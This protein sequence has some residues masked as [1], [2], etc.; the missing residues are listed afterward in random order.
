MITLSNAHTG[1]T[2][3]PVERFL[4]ARHR[5]NNSGC[6]L[7]HDA[8]L[9]LTGRKWRPREDRYLVRGRPGS[10]QYNP[11]E[12]GVRVG[13]QPR[14][15]STRQPAL[16]AHLAGTEPTAP[17]GLCQRLL[18]ELHAVSVD[19]SPTS[20]QGEAAPGLANA[21][22][23]PQTS[24]AHLCLDLPGRD[25]N[26]PPCESPLLRRPAV[27][28]PATLITLQMT[29]FLVTSQRKMTRGLAWEMLTRRNTGGRQ[30]LTR[31]PEA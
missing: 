11:R 14:G 9:H 18:L 31:R 12:P 26:H 3:H 19:E 22:V 5:F 16:S 23:K 20:L 17:R 30:P 1:I 25:L 21:G 7:F 13:S 28:T 2:I 27:Y 6:P 29:C 4:G 8:F 10:K 24:S 15:P